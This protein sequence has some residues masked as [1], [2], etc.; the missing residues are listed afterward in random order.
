MPLSSFSA[1]TPRWCGWCQQPLQGRSDKRFCDAACRNKAA[2]HGVV[3]GTLIDWPARAA[4][5]EQTVQAL[6]AHLDQL[7]QAQQAVAPLERRYD[8]FTQVVN[9]LVPELESSGLLANLR[10]YI[11]GLLA[12]YEQHPGLAAGEEAPLR[13]VQILRQLHATI[14]HQYHRL[15]PVSPVGPA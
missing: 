2:R 10:Q 5:A 12:D 8:E 13:R 6:Q 9:V 7:A 11:E 14:E 15:H 4:H 3:G 1:L